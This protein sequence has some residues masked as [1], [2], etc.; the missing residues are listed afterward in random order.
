M[1]AN[2]LS[3]AV[4]GNL[5]LIIKSLSSVW[6]AIGLSVAVTALLL[7]LIAL[8]CKRRKLNLISLLLAG[9]LAAALTFPMMGLTGAVRAKS[10][11]VDGQMSLEQLLQNIQTHPYG[12][13]ALGAIDCLD[14][15]PPKADRIMQYLLSGEAVNELASSAQD[16]LDSYILR[17]VLLLVLFVAVGTLLIVL[18]MEQTG[19][20]HGGSRGSRSH[21]TSSY[22]SDDVTTTSR[23]RGYS[24]RSSYDDF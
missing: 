11:V 12:A 8:F 22:T 18:T 13:M 4:S 10:Y 2:Y 5:N 20:R 19:G 14:L 1:F 23:S 21:R 17:R 7:L 9:C 24:S 16:Y 3:R 15:L 6:A